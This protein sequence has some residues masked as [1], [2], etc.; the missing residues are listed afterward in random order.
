MN[1]IGLGIVLVIAAV[2]GVIFGVHGRFD[3]D[4]SALFFDPVAHVFTIG[5]SPW[6]QLTRKMAR[7]LI[8]LIALPSFI[9]I[10]GK[11]VLPRRRMV[12][13]GRTALYLVLTLTI[14]PGL[15][16][17]TLLKDHWGRMRP[18]DIVEFLGDSRFT[19]WWD[20]RGPCP[21]N[22]SFVAG[23]PAGAFW[24]LAPA[25]MA[26]SQWRL[27]AYGG[28]FVFGLA[29]GLLRIAAGGHFFTDVVFS[30]VFMY[31]VAW[32]FHG[33]IF[34]WRA[35]RLDEDSVEHA[36]ARAGEAIRSALTAVTGRRGQKPDKHS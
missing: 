26:P 10:F 33:I 31:L 21:N 12:I 34:R 22:C 17:N 24:T 9:A 1:R 30:G 27:L 8:T 25:A 7:T 4:F 36:L 28:A 5:G 6:E 20:P 32:I 16:T 19:P 2:V 15:I 13:D 23:E 11:L 29:I 3:I 35:T 18:I 14:G